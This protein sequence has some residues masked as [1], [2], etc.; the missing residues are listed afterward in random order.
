MATDWTFMGGFVKGSMV[1]LE[2]L[3]PLSWQPR[4][5]VFSLKSENVQK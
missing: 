3:S 5:P 1:K 4:S 2:L